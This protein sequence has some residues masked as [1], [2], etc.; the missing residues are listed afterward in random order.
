MKG[1]VLQQY[2]L[3]LVENRFEEF[4]QKLSS[5]F[6][7]YFGKLL[8][9]QHSY[10]DWLVIQLRP[11]RRQSC[12]QSEIKS[13]SR[14]FVMLIQFLNY[15]QHLDFEIKYIDQISYRVVGF[16]LKDFLRFQ[17]KYK[18]RKVKEFFE[19]VQTGILLTSFSDN[20]F[21]S[22]VGIPLVKFHKIQKFWV[23]RVW[24]AEELFY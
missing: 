18:L 17:N 9:L 21:Q 13:D 22:L 19:E 1:K 14:K 7:L 6:T 16:R 23:G 5:Y 4:E 12:I 11:M 15:A 20:Y 10:L 8:P 3:L 24:L 2:Y